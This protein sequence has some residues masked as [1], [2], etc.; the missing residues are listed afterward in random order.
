MPGKQIPLYA[1]Q[2]DLLAVV[3]EACSVRP[4]EF[5]VMGLFDE[6]K[7]T[8]LNDP[9]KLLPFTAYLVFDKGLGVI[10]R[11]VSQRKGGVKYAVDPME[12]PQ[13]IV[14]RCGGLFDAQRLI[15]GD[16][17]TATRDAQSEALYALFAKVIRRR[18][19]KI[20]SY[21]VGPAATQLLDSGVRLTSGAKSPETYDLVR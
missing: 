11:Q 13:A 9:E 2:S 15:A 4:L 7:P 6:A 8:V 20:R 16:I 10:V 18:F 17:S 12:N 19:D 3:Q 1:T 5:A 21:Y 14:L